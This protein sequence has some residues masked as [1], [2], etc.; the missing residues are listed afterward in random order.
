[1]QDIVGKE[2][3]FIEIQNHG[4]EEQLKIT[5]QLIQIADTIGARIVP[6]GDC[7]YVKKEDAHF[8]D[9]MLC[10]ATNSNIHTENRFSFS[11]DNFYLKSYDEMASCF[12]E[13]WLKNTLIVSDMVD[14][15]LSFGDLHFPNYPIPENK[16]PN[17]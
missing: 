13:S 8:H 4:L 10:V 15:N 9:V 17:E 11:G 14:V 12:D 6:T 3:Y 1:M 16:N 2:N 5:K 7:H